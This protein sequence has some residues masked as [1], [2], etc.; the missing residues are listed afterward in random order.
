MKNLRVLLIFTI[1][2]ASGVV[3]VNGQTSKSESITALIKK[4][5][6]FNKKN[7][8]GF[9]IQ[10]Y[11]GLEVKAKKELALF[12]LKFP[13]IKTFID[14]SNPPHWKAHVGNYQNR[15]EADKALNEIKLIFPGAIVIKK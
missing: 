8:Y 13:T 11:Y 7:G 5:R 4:K 3:S 6:E 1:I 14:Y 2:F 15:L 10:L 12:R 9:K